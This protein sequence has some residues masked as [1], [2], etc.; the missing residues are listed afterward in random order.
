MQ[1]LKTV[2]L[3]VKECHLEA[4]IIFTMMVFLGGVQR[5]RKSKKIYDA[6]TF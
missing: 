1:L 2:I 3:I 6:E 5:L 4:V